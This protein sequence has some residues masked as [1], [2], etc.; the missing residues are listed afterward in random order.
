MA[1]ENS[2]SRYAHICASCASF[3]D[4]EETSHMPVDE[5]VEEPNAQEA[6]EHSHKP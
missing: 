5:S 2:H 4:G 6:R 1:A 3:L